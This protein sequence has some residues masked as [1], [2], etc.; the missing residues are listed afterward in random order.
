MSEST[1]AKLQPVNTSPDD[2]RARFD[3][4]HEDVQQILQTLRDMKE[5]QEAKRQE[6]APKGAQK[7]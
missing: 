7:R 5:Q 6:P 1:A 2:L 4:L 3:Q